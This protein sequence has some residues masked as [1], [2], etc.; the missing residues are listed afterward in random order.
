MGGNRETTMQRRALLEFAVRSGLANPRE[1]PD[2]YFLLMFWTPEDSLGGPEP[3]EDFLS[4]LGKNAGGA[5]RAFAEEALGAREFKAAWAARFGELPSTEAFWLYLAKGAICRQPSGCLEELCE[6]DGLDFARA[7]EARAPEGGWLGRRRKKARDFQDPCQAE[8]FKALRLAWADELSRKLAAD[9]P[10]RLDEALARFFKEDPSPCPLRL[11][12]LP[13]WGASVIEWLDDLW[14]EL[15]EAKCGPQDLRFEAL[16]PPMLQVFDELTLPAL[17]KRRGCRI[18][19]EGT[20]LLG[21]GPR[22]RWPR[23]FAVLAPACARW[24]KENPDL[25]RQKAMFRDEGFSIDLYEQY[26]A[27]LAAIGEGAA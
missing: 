16:V 23:L 9:L 18:A 1:R 14:K 17:P 15:R 24:T 22:N 19:R 26:T 20:R 12:A 3:L 10:R 4:G 27:W 13:L 5:L 7:L 8:I 2:Q 25:K 21:L 6:K 11:L